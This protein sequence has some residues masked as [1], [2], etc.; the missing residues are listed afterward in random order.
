MIRCLRISIGNMRGLLAS[1]QGSPTL[2]RKAASG[3]SG[4]CDD[5]CSFACCNWHELKTQDS[6]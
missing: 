4:C 2:D 6:M 3:G 5:T 1:V